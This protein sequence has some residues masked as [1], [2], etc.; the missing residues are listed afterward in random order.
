MIRIYKYTLD[1]KDFQLIDISGFI[2]ILSVIEQDDKLVL[3]T[4]IDSESRISSAIPIFI[5]GTGNDCDEAYNKRF[6]NSVSMFDG[7]LIW[8]VFTNMGVRI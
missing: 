5:Y 2:K 8:H 6:I 3:Y 4:I 1:I 7:R